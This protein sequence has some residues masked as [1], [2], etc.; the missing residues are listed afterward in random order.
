MG[1]LKKMVVTVPSR[2]LNEIDTMAMDDGRDR[3]EFVREAIHFYVK[4]RA[5][6]DMCSKLKEGYIRMGKVNLQL[7]Q[8]AEVYDDY[9]L[10]NYEHVL[11]ESEDVGD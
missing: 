9:M 8:E 5:Q 10:V 11:A 3:S 7:A 2:L 6:S 4:R 1:E